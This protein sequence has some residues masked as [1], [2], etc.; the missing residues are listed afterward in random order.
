MVGADRD[1]PLIAAAGS[2][3]HITVMLHFE[4]AAL[5]AQVA[6]TLWLIIALVGFSFRRSTPWLICAAFAALA[7]LSVVVVIADGTA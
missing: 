4:G 2:N 3:P 6:V 5:L 1:N 7:L